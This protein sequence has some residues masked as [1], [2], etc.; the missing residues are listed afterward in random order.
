MNSSELERSRIF[1]CDAV[2]CEDVVEY[3]TSHP[4]RQ[5]FSYPGP[6]KPLFWVQEI[7]HSDAFCDSATWIYTY[8]QRRALCRQ[9][10]ESH[11]VTEI[12]GHTVVSLCYDGLS[13]DQLTS[14]RPATSKKVWASW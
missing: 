2:D 8:L 12:D 1:R 7:L 4:R 3:A 11:D 9:C 6:S 14:D 5:H 13:Q 10:G